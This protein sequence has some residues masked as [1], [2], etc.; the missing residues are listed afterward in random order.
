MAS[1]IGALPVTPLFAVGNNYSWAC[2]P[3]DSDLLR[4]VTFPKAEP[5]AALSVAQRTWHIA[6]EESEY[7]FNLQLAE[8][9]SEIVLSANVHRSLEG[10]DLDK[11]VEPALT[12][13]EMHV[14]FREKVA[15]MFLD[16]LDIEVNA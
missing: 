13:A 9:K 15:E 14:E 10:F 16:T 2:K 4:T 1:V 6:V 7:T 5:D 3:E 11:R 8:Q 12:S